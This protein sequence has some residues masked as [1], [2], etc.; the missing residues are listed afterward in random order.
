MPQQNAQPTKLTPALALQ[1]ISI[2]LDGATH[3][4]VA[5]TRVVLGSMDLVAN[6][7]QAGEAAIKELAAAQTELAKARQAA[8]PV[9]VPEDG[10]Q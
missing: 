4:T 8:A 9:G 3:L 2:A 10:G 7:M 1:N 5:N 6:Y